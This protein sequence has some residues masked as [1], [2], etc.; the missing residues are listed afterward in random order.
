MVDWHCA[1]GP[2]NGG[3]AAAAARAAA[4]GRLE[5]AS[6]IV[7]STG[8]DRRERSGRRG[9]SGNGACCCWAA[10]AK[11]YNGRLSL[12]GKGKETTLDVPGLSSALGSTSS[13]LISTGAV[14][15]GTTIGGT[16]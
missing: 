13:S 10:A 8:S 9:G 3:G 12:L 4:A 14:R 6:G 5:G 1:V 11:R 2:G 16:K 7:G 15:V